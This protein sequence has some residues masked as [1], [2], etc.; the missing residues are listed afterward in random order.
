MAIVNEDD[1][2]EQDVSVAICGDNIRLRLKGIDDSEISPGF[3][4]T[5]PQHPVH[6]VTRFEV[7]LSILETKNIISAGYNAIIHAVRWHLI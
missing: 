4:L 1:Q 3:V 2:S 7:I 6:A 5:D